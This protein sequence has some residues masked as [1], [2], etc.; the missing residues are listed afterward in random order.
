LKLLGQSASKEKND[1]AQDRR[2]YFQQAFS[3][4]LTNPKAILFFM[5]F[6]PLFLPVGSHCL[7][8]VIMMAHVSLISLLYQS[9]LVFV[10][11]FV[12]ARLSKFRNAG[13]ITRRL[14][15]LGFIAFGI[16]LALTRR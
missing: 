15:G 14:V 10:G 2:F 11:N 12:M 1:A 5:A 9:G 6:F 7:T 8:L 16:K 3:V 13:E 4:C